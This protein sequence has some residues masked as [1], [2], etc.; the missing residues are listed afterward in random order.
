MTD[1][2]CPRDC[3]YLYPTEEQQQAIQGA[4]PWIYKIHRCRKYGCDLKHL[5]SHPDLY[6]CKECYK[7]NKQ[8]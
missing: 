4:I 8:C 1:K 2:Y 5:D 6:K 7:E 3:Q